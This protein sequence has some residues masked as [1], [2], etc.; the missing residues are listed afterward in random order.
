MG[1]R[2]LICV[3]SD[4]EFKV[5]QYCQWDGYPEGQGRTIAR[6]L[7]DK[8]RVA[9]LRDAIV[10]T[11]L[12]TDDEFEI[13]HKENIEPMTGGERYISMDVSKRINDTFPQMDRSLGGNILQFLVDNATPENVIPLMNSTSFAS[14]SL[15]CE[16][17]Y[18]VDLDS[19]ALEVY[20]GFSN[21]SPCELNKFGHL[22]VDP[23][24]KYGLVSFACAIPFEKL[25]SESPVNE[26]RLAFPEV[27]DY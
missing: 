13:W 25:T 21:R 11:K 14:D 8:N 26:V 16:W 24:E 18:I 3:F 20:K 9:S 4:D 15:F 22:T 7:L 17:A 5:A 6:F 27:E 19:E 1:T 23:N 10:H 2:N 12:L